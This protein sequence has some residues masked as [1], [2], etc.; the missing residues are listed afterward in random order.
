VRASLPPGVALLEYALGAER[1]Y[2]FVL[3]RSA[4]SAFPVPPAGEVSRLVGE[5]RDALDTRSPLSRPRAQAAAQQLHRVLLTPAREALTQVDRLVVVPDRDLFYLP[6]EL[7]VGGEGAAPTA[8]VERWTITY[9]PSAGVLDQLRGRRAGRAWRADLLAFA[10]PPPAPEPTGGASDLPAELAGAAR[11]PPLPGARA[12]VAAIAALFPPDRVE[13]RVGAE[14]R[15]SRLKQAGATA[16]VRRLH[17]ASHGVLADVDPA[18]AF[19]LMAPGP[20][21]GEDGRLRVHEVFNLDLDSELV[22]LS[23]CE[24]G[25]GQRMLGEGLIGMTRAFLHA[26]A[27][28]VVVSLWPVGDR[29]AKELLVDFYRGLGSGL[30]AADALRRA[31]LARL[32]TP[33][34]DDPL[35]WAS[36]VLVGAGG[37]L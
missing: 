14:A 20:E 15:E 29:A 36:F 7:L 1:S 34:A 22:V 12:E 27:R 28:D 16:G 25:L 35:D 33:A 19:L 17:I 4:F 37:P 13:V 9:V 21:A 2:L 8:A 5:V 11:L 18:D 3:S 6:F 24:T 30:S 10:D 31:K 26:G 23:G 32:A